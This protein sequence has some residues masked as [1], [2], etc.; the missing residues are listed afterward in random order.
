MTT[1]N[2]NNE[3][4]RVLAYTQELVSNKAKMAVYDATAIMIAQLQRRH[5]IS[6]VNTKEMRIIANEIY[7]RLERECINRVLPV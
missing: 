2:Q 5:N 1:T 6:Q 7:L 3:L 4:S